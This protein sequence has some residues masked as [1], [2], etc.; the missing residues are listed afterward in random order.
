MHDPTTL[1]AG[2][3]ESSGKICPSPPGAKRLVVNADDFGMS[4]GINNGIAE[5]HRRGILTSATLMATG[6]AFAQA[7]ILAKSLPKLGVGVH[8][9]LT[10]GTPLSDHATVPSLVNARGEFYSHPATLLRRQLTGRLRASDV[11]RELAAQ[12]EKVRAAGITITH[13][14]GHKHVQMLPGVLNIVIRLAKNFRIAGVRC[15]AERAPRLWILL[16][17]NK[18][19]AFKIVQQ[20]VQ[21][22]TLQR[23]TSNARAQLRE[24]RLN[25]PRDFYGITHT[26]FLDCIQIAEI[27]R[28]LRPGTSELM[29]HPGHVDENIATNLTR[30]KSER[31]RELDALT[32]PDTLQLV[33]RLGIHLINYRGLL[34]D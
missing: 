10:Q 11:E 27:L 9:N 33:A 4:V 2:V 31:E 16:K 20:Y 34:T 29:C 6:E 22:R 13:L 12:I 23:I 19:Y 28:A 15:S 7:V 30:L 25:F 24:A 14:D 3:E 5:A 26:G 17:S 18:K 32:R 8:L 21:A 1:G